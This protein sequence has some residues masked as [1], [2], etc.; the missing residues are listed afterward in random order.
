KEQDSGDARLSF[1]ITL[2]DTAGQKQSKTVSRVVTNQPLRIEV[3]P[4]NGALVAGVANTVYLYVSYADGRP[5]VATVTL[6]GKELTLKTS[7]LGIASF[8]TAAE[9]PTLDYA[10]RATD[11]AGRVGRKAVNLSFNSPARDFLLRTDR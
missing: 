11:G 2:Y 3:I 5:A 6:S 8:E 10:I 1:T 9:N 7:A 4:E